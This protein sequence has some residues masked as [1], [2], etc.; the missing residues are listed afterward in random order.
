MSKNLNKVQLTGNLGKDPET[1]YTPQGSAITKFSVASSRSWR[2][3]EGEDRED[4]EWFN[5][6]AW[7]KLGEICAQYL[8]KGSRVYIEGRLQTRSWDD[9][10]TGQKRYM[11]EVIASDMIMLDSRRD[12]MADAP[13]YE[14]ADAGYPEQPDPDMDAAPRAYQQSAPRGQQPPARPAG[15]GGGFGN[16]AP[17]RQPQRPAPAQA[18]ANGAPRRPV[19]P[20][21]TDEDDLPF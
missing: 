5:V 7:N 8:Q 6:V 16:G 11:T 2:T 9:Q 19:A 3:A 13:A 20:P 15:N 21:T 10:Q 12:R 18:P 14:E 17:A 1:R 4:T